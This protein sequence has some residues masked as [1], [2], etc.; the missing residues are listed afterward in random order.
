MLLKKQVYDLTWRNNLDLQIS[1]IQIHRKEKWSF[2]FRS[3]FTR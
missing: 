1:G 3:P 2:I